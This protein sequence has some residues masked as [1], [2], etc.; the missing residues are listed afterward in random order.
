MALR[1]H[2]ANFIR[3]CGRVSL[4][5]STYSDIVKNYSA[6]YPSQSVATGMSSLTPSA[7]PTAPSLKHL[8]ITDGLI[9]TPVAKKPRE[10]EQ[11]GTESTFP[12][13]LTVPRSVAPSVDSFAP[14]VTQAR[15]VQANPVDSLTVRYQHSHGGG[16]ASRRPGDP[17]ATQ[18]TAYLQS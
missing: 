18:P 12:R 16:P 11:R 7:S 15:C 6:N 4:S 9:H 5:P 8:G 17:Q 10:L 1:H 3:Y 2:L 13:P 14:T